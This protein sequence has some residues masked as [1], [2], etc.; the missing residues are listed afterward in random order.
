M[1][2]KYIIKICN[3]NIIANSSFSWWGA[4][5]N[6]NT[7]KIVCRPNKWFNIKY[8]NFNDNDLSPDTWIKF[9]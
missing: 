8:N 3:H 4:Y 6:K 7:D 2:I 9:Q 1:I 5:F